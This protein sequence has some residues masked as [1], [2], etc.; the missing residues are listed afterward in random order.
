MYVRDSANVGVSATY[1]VTKEIGLTVSGMNLTDSQYYAYANTQRLPRG[2]Y[3]N[4]RKLLATV[5][6]NF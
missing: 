5:N 6:V 3:R 2:V 1:D 4:G